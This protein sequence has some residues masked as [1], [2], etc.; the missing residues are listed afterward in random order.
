[1]S[2]DQVATQLAFV[3]HSFADQRKPAALWWTGWTSFNLFN[4][5]LGWWKFATARTRLAY[6]SW[7]VSA[8]GATMFVAGAAIVPLPGMYGYRRLSFMPDDTPKARRTKLVSALELMEKA[9]QV[10]SLN[11][12]WMAQVAAVAYATLSTGYVWVRNRDADPHKL[13]LAV[14]LQFATS[15]LVAELTFLSVPRRARRDLKK[16]RTGVCAE[17]RERERTPP[18]SLQP[19]IREAHA[20][21]SIQL[22]VSAIWLVGRF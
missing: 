5:G 10:E 6:D 12:N 4:V 17:P 19:A 3:H 21:F 22:G 9:A 16:I 8:I 20:S 13:T 18:P 15:I 1:L 2:D 7:L 11:S 14:T